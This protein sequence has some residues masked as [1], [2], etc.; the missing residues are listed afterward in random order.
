MLSEQSVF[1]HSAAIVI[2]SPASDACKA[3]VLTG[4]LSYCI[5]KTNYETACIFIDISLPRCALAP[6]RPKGRILAYFEL[7]TRRPVADHF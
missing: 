4:E 3:G 6:T 1:R 2:A 5:T 7:K